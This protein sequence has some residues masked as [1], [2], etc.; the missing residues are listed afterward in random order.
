MSEV[1]DPTPGNHT[2]MSTAEFYEALDVAHA[3]GYRDGVR[4]ERAELRKR[5]E[6]VLTDAT[7]AIRAV[8]EP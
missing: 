8:V 4:N 7:A 1:P 2:P 5:L 6:A 3:K